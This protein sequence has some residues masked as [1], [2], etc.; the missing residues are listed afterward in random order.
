MSMSQ[1]C[2]HMHIR[3]RGAVNTGTI[4]IYALAIEFFSIFAKIMY[5]YMVY[6]TVVSCI[7]YS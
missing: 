2:M 6:V 5:I 3:I 1:S 4:H 7:S